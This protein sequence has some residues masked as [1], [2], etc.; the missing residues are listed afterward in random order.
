[1]LVQEHMTTSP[2]TIKNDKSIQDALNILKKHKLRGLPVMAGDRLV[3]LVTEKE[4]LAVTPSPAT[5]LSVYEIK[6]LLSKLAVKDVMIKTP[7]T[8]DSDCTIEES[9]LVMR[10]HR[11]G[12][13]PVMDDREKLVGVITQTDIFDALIQLFGLRKVGTRIVLEAKNKIGLISELTGVVSSFNINV[14]SIAVWEKSQHNL[15]VILRLST[16]EPDQIIE[17][18]KKHGYNII[19]VS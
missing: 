6:D 8:I 12:F 10:E 17:E 14:I 16:V 13:L 19:L 1:M 4:L 9:A 3:G 18:F 7:I 15:Q 11:I 2:I 5:T